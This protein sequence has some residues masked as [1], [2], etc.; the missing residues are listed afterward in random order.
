MKRQVLDRL[1]K[2]IVRIGGT[3]QADNVCG[4]IREDIRHARVLMP[5]H[6]PAPCTRPGPLAF[7]EALTRQ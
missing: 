7:A 5:S 1:G 3:Q 4:E 6:D 2:R